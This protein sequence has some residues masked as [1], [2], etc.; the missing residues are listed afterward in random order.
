MLQFN[1]KNKI[2]RMKKYRFYKYLY[3]KVTEC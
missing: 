1:Y 2:I 3:K